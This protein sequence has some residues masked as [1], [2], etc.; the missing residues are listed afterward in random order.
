MQDVEDAAK[1]KRAAEEHAVR[2]TK[3]QKRE[4]MIQREASREAAKVAKEAADIILLYDNFKSIVSAI[5]EG[6]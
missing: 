5:E 4:A 2:E 6:R 1:R 3:R